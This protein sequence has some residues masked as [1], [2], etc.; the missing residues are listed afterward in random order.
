MKFRK[1]NKL[2]LFLLVGIIITG[3]GIRE[4]LPE[5]GDNNEDGIVQENYENPISLDVSAKDYNLLMR[6]EDISDSVVNLYGI[7]NATSIVLNDMVAIAVE[8]AE[9]YTFSEELKQT[10]TN[11]V[12]ENDS[13]IKQ[14][15]ITD[16]KQIFNEIESVIEDLLN[17][18]SY[19]SQ[20]EK[21]NNIIEKIKSW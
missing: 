7:D 6:S 17:G 10:I 14:V 2:L 12:K 3:C 9:D 15:Y 20:V 4:N 21:I 19:D 5:E 1:I 11:T 13:L 16:N 18:Q 8:V